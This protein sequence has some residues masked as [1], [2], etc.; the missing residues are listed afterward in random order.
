MMAPP[1]QQMA[2]QQ[3]M[4]ARGGYFNGRK[5]Y[6]G[7]GEI[8]PTIIPATDEHPSYFEGIAYD[9]PSDTSSPSYPVSINPTQYDKYTGKSTTAP[10]GWRPQSNIMGSAST[11]GN[12]M[13][14]ESWQSI[15][16]GTAQA[17]PGIAGAAFAF[18]K[19]K[20]RK[21]TPSLA[22]SVN[23]DYTPE[24][25]ALKE[26]G[27]RGIGMALDTMKRNAPTSGSYMN[28]AREAVLRG[29]KVIGSQI[30]KSWQD[31]KNEQAKY[32]FDIGKINTDTRNKTNEINESMYQNAM[33][34]GFRSS[35]D[36]ISKTSNYYTGKENR[37]IQ[38][39]QAQNTNTT[40]TRWLILPDGSKVQVHKNANGEFWHNGKKVE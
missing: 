40:N 20:D 30:S 18:G 21:L 26:E 2:P 27:R 37:D 35:Q 22:S 14:P 10:T 34:Q 38:R 15:A 17:L 39:W 33:E 8:P 28:N 5:Q 32:D 19:L 16:A 25:V 7:S 31:Q 12:E 6:A 9:N 29:N 3:G 23:I 36:A 13:F 11:E 4:M 24:R 1:Q